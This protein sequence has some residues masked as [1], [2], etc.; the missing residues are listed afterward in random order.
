VGHN[1][2]VSREHPGRAIPRDAA[3]PQEGTDTC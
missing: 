2:H 3:R 1:D